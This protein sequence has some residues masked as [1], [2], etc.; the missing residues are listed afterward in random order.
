MTNYSYRKKPLVIEAVQVQKAMLTAIDLPEWFWEAVDKGTIDLR[1]QSP[2]TRH[3]PWA[4][5]ETLEG[6]MRADHG[7]WI[8]QGIKKEIYSCKK[9]IFDMTYEREV[10][11]KEDGWTSALDELKVKTI[12]TAPEKFCITP[13]PLFVKTITNGNMLSHGKTAGEAT[14]A[15]MHR[16]LDEWMVTVVKEEKRRREA[17][18]AFGG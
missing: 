17:V 9:D 14:R 10:V 8:I 7:D 6:T 2:F 18:D 11:V 12:S 13:G 4:E 15:D 1:N 3:E 5:I 16:K